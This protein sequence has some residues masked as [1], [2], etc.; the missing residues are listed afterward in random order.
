MTDRRS[1]ILELVIVIGFCVFL[2]FYNL[3]GVGLLG[4]GLGAVEAVTCDHRLPDHR[5]AAFLAGRAGQLGVGDQPGLRLGA[6][7][8]AESVAPGG[9]RLAGVAG[10]GIDGGDHAVRRDAA[11]DP[12][13]AVHAL[14]DVL[15]DHRRE[16]RRRLRH[17]GR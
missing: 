12:K 14:F 13:H 2:F 9:L 7:M 5:I 3:T 6:D 17:V 1:T 8:P 10:L 16:Q 15:T 11:H 4:L